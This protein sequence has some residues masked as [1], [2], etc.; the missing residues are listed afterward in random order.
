MFFLSRHFYNNQPCKY[1][2]AIL[3]VLS[4][5][6]RKVLHLYSWGIFNKM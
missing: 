4:N 2:V 3:A 6:S 1:C 5:L